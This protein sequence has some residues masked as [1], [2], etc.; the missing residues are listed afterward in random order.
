MRL[1]CLLLLR[2]LPHYQ[3]LELFMFAFKQTLECVLQVEE[4]MEAISDLLR[5]GSPFARSDVA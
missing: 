1:L 5:L 3:V 2:W 4:Q